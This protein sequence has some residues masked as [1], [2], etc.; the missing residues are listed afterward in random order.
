[1][2]L[3]DITL[4]V[5]QALATTGVRVYTS[6]PDAGDFPALVVN[7]PT[8]ITYT[9][10]HAGSCIIELPITLYTQGSDMASAWKLIYQLLSYDQS[11]TT[12][13]ADALISHTPTN[14]KSLQ[15]TTAS[16]FRPN[17]DGIAVDINLVIHS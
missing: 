8:T 12:P 7:P 10:S 3:S 11:T 1:M 4:E 9:K 2:N 13:V 6:V 5:G 15:V 16:N 17:G 14:Y